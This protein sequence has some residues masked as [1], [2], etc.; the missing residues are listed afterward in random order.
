MAALFFAEM[1]FD[2]KDP[3]HPEAD[4][5]VLSKGHA[6]A[7]PLRRVG[8]GRRVSARGPAEAAQDRRPI[9]KAIRRRG[10]RSSTSRPD[11]SARALRRRRRHRAQRAPHR[12]R[13][14]HVRAARRRR[15]RP[16]A[17][18][19]K[20]RTSR[21]HQ[22]LDNLCA[23]HRRQR[24]RP[25]PARR[26]GITTSRRSRARWRAFGWHAIV[27][28]RPRPRRRSSTAL[29]EA[30][31]T[32]GQPTMIVARHA[33]GQGRL[34]LRR[35]GRLARQGAQE[36]RRSSTRRSPSS[37]R[38]SCKT[39]DPAPAIPKP[40]DAAAPKGRCRTFDEAHAGARLQAGRHGRDAR[41]VRHGARRARRRSIARIVAL[42]ADVKN[43]TF[44][45][46]FE[47]AHPGPLLSR[48]SSPSR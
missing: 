6:R 21:A 30:R 33:Q 12:V 1:R 7:D 11:R 27:D 20:R 35:Q 16:K 37:K 25:E 43:S 32:K 39:T 48:S 46:K 19:G 5:F 23:H 8:G 38:S 29:D 31:A 13:L 15:D 34:D 45:E 26:S 42:D 36:G 14:P 41:G 47:K 2:P 10:C 40:R 17:R 9:S 18:C 3:Q 24:P 28:R 4:R 22:K 44:S